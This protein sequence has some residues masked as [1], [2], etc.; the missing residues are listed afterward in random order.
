MAFH[1]HRRRSITLTLLGTS[2][3]VIHGA[4]GADVLLRFNAPTDPVVA[5]SG[6]ATLKYYDP[7]TSG[8]GPGATQF[9]KASSLGLPGM[10]RGDPDV[11]FFPACGPQ[12]GYELT[13]GFP[14]NG[15]Y[16]GTL[17]MTSN[18]T[19]IHDVY[20]PPE[21]GG[22]WRALLQTSPVNGDDGE[23]FLQNSAA[24]GV[25]INGNYRGT[26][27][28][29]VW[30]RIAISVRSAPGEGQAQRYID[31]QFVGAIGTTGSALEERF[32]LPSGTP[33]P[34]LLLTDNDNETAPG[35]I[36]GFYIVD[37][38]MNAAEITALGGPNAAG[39]NVPGAAAPAYASKMTRLAGAIGHRGG[40]YGSYPDNT[41][42]ALRQAFLD[43]AKGV[44]VDTRLTSDGVAVCFHDAT[45]DRT[46]D[47][48]GDVSSL[49]LA[50]L[51]LLDA[52]AKYDPA[53]AG[54]R[55]PT[56]AEALTEA[57]GK[58]IVYLDIKTKDQ[59]D[60]SAAAFAAA[61]AQSGFPLADLWF[62]APDDDVLAAAVRAKV[63]GAKILWGGPAEDW[64]SNPGYFQDLRDKGVIGFS[65]GTGTGA[66]DP[67]FVSRAK[68]EG[69][70]VEVYTINDPDTMLACAAAGV[71][72]ME[73]DF[74]ATAAALQPAQQAKA[75]LPGPAAGGA[76]ST[77]SA[78]LTWVPAT[79]AT[80]H[81]VS[82]GTVNP[83][84][85]VREQTSDLYFTGMLAQSQTYYWRVDEITPGGIVT[86]DVWSFTT[87]APATGTILEWG[88][89]GSL[90][91]AIGGGVLEY[92]DGE[93]TKG[94]VVFETSDDANVP[95]IN[96]DPVSY[97]RIPAFFS[98]SDGLALTFPAS[99][100]PNGGGVDVNR[101]S[102][103]FDVL[104]P[105]T[106]SYSNFFNTSP[107]NNNDG[108]FF[109]RGDGALGIAALGYSSAGVI[110]SGEWQRI[111]FSAD[112]PSGTVTYYVDGA[113][114]LTKT[115][116]AL[117]GG[118]FSLFP[119]TGAGPHVRLL[120]DEDG[121][122]MEMMVS[123]VAF[124]DAPLTA[125]QASDLGGVKPAGIF[126]T[127]ATLPP[128]TITRTGNSVI[129]TW[130][131]AAGRRLQRSVNLSTW[132]DVPGTTGQGTWTETIQAGAKV[133][134]RTAE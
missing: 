109:V 24:G 98:A 33:D 55:V 131:A 96:G 66:P 110:H 90:A 13:T 46:T 31:G 97:L 16:A 1:P 68:Q 50:A 132:T 104:M 123:A 99:I 45:V 103:V 118:R 78:T 125:S 6:N 44:E 51:K 121:E 47:G 107:G 23:F 108:D 117:T 120:N 17:G 48:S 2:L 83:P 52:G 62:W 72:Y 119:G 41:I 30:H 27:T 112:L 94:Q 20:F 34:V 22:K 59:P 53:F 128:V 40:S 57:K 71:D 93:N 56:L 87:A 11:M 54:T 39:A 86:G 113:P 43:G 61:I 12:Q 133:F 124:I 74:P 102:F 35:Y 91:A 38:A 101:Y 28:T 127:A 105:A 65:M 122:M 29:G 3:L 82:F 126:R 7:E 15:A 9:G 76:V 32:A 100:A 60:A 95:H 130:T 88:F 8:W 81:R 80:S 42:P 4:S 63:P 21:S 69:F 92:A 85:F 114:V 14:P 73:T 67:A 36:S 84:P 19:V 26:V 111:I 116:A 49:S 10:T 64:A 5:S 77:P 18:Y 106:G 115:G 37:R 70:I 75:S 58:G 134:F 129:L 89:D 25:G 79:G